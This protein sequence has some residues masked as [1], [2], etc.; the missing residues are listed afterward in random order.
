LHNKK[1]LENVTDDLAK[2]FAGIEV[3]ARPN[4]AGIAMQIIQE[5]MHNNLMLQ[6]RLQGDQ[7]FQARFQKYVQQYQFMQTQAQNAQIGRI[8]T[9]PS[10]MGQMN[11]Q[12]MNQ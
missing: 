6:Q 7:A 1:W 11:T 8:G 10:A 2:I 12:N 4:G 3:P 5:T 9:D